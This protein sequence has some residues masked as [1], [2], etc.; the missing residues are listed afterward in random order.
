[1]EYGMTFLGTGAAEGIPNPFCQ[2]GICENARR[3]GG[4]E[5][6]TRSAFRLNERVH[7]DYGPDTFAQALKCGI[8]L[9]A[10]KHII[11]THT[12]EDHYCVNQLNLRQMAR[13]RG[14]EPLR[15]YLTSPAYKW[16]FERMT[17]HELSLIKNGIVQLVEIDYLKEYVI[18]GM[19]VRAFPGNHRGH[20]EH[21]Q[22]ANYLITLPDGRTM[23]YAVDTGYYFEDTFGLLQS[24]TLDLL[25]MECTFGSHALAPGAEHLDIY[26]FIRVLETLL[27]QG[28]INQDTR[29]LATHIN[30]ADGLDYDGLQ[31]YF[32]NNAPVTVEIAYDGLMI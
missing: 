19:K 18:G 22:A 12:H 9:H 24:H 4:V 3:K 31:Q 17:K 21:E 28:T 23:Y 6:R 32:A 15:I 2:C 25:V 29:I 8:N 1:M 30:H 7:I 20:G 26:S 27:Q 13:D 11:V 10:L 14:E 5:V 16:A